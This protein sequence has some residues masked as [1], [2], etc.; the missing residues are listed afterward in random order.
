V[1]TLGVNDCPQADC[2]DPAEGYLTPGVWGGDN[3]EISVDTDGM[4]RVRTYCASGLSQEPVAAQDGNVTFAADMIFEFG[5]PGRPGEARFDGQVCGDTFEFIYET[6]YGY[7]EEASVQFGV[8]G[9]IEPCPY[10]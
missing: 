3:W 4:I 7:T 2:P 5:G 6:D 9:K 8:E 10:L 1:M